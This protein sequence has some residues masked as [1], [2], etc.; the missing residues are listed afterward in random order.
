MRDAGCGVRGV[1]CGV[2]SAVQDGA[3]TSIDVP[4]SSRTSDCRDA[5]FCARPERHVD[6]CSLHFEYATTTLAQTDES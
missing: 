5:F 2:T 4:E 6:S 1:G 3:S